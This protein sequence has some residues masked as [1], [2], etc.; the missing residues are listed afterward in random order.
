VEVREHY[1]RIMKQSRQF[2]VEQKNL[3]KSIKDRQKQVQEEEEKELL[4]KMEADQLHQDGGA[5]NNPE[6]QRAK[7]KDLMKQLQRQT[8][9]TIEKEQTSATERRIKMMEDKKQELGESLKSYITDHIKQQPNKIKDKAMDNLLLRTLPAGIK[10]ERKGSP[11]L[12]RDSAPSYPSFIKVLYCGM[13][14][15]ILFLM[16][17]FFTFFN[18]FI[19]NTMVTVFIIYVLEKIIQEIRS[20]FGEKNVSKKSLTNECFLI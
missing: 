4:K 15:K 2:D 12:I 10:V 20:H 16:I 17:E 14:F 7:A 18:Y 19:E 8:K 11:W 5:D 1:D 6:Q 3:K 9:S 13:D